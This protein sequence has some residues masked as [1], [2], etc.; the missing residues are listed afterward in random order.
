MQDRH[1]NESGFLTRVTENLAASH[2]QLHNP[3][4]VKSQKEL[5]WLVISF[6]VAAG[7]LF[8]SNG[9]QAGFHSLNGISYIFPTSFLQIITFMGDTLVCLTLLLPFARRK[10][11]VLVIAMLAAVFGTLASKGLKIG[12]DMPRPPA[13]IHAE[14]FFLT[15]EAH[16]RYSFPSGHSLTIFSLLTLLYY[17]SNKA[18]TKLLLIL[19]GSSVAISRVLVGVHWPIDVLIG[20]ALGIAISLAAIKT[21][22]HWRAAFTPSF[23][24]CALTMVLTAVFMLFQHDGG[25]TE[26]KHFAVT[27]SCV[28]LAH[29]IYDSAINGNLEDAMTQGVANK[30]QVTK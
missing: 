8:L 3:E 5:C 17:F 20:S 11:A 18:S 28:A 30:S 15:G 16:S 24:F 12:F 21:A 10:P 6:V 1:C 7:I 23:C 14:E 4:Q 26:A 13:I 9:Y 25:Y 27:L 2:S 22:K 29:F 19:F